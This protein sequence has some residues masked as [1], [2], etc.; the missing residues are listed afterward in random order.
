[1]RALN[2]AFAKYI[3][4]LS[5]D[6][7]EEDLY[8]ENEVANTNYDD[9]DEDENG[10]LIEIYT[11][12]YL[13][14]ADRPEITFGFLPDGYGT[15]YTTGPHTFRNEIN[16][17]L[18]PDILKKVADWI[19]DADQEIL[20]KIFIDFDTANDIFNELDN[21]GS[22]YGCIDSLAIEDIINKYIID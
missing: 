22:Q 5:E 9:E 8:N 11:E 19:E 6:F 7:D 18:S 2:E 13:P 3:G 21:Y 12:F 16:C 20:E 10:D 15:V 4:S 14:I 1:M 17:E